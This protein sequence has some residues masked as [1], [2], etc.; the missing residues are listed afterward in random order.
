MVSNSLTLKLKEFHAISLEELNRAPLMNR[1]DEKFAFPLSKLEV[2]L[3][4]LKHYYDVLSIDN[5]EIFAYTSQYFDDDTFQFF[6]D[7]HRALPNRFKVRIRKYLDSGL[8]FLEV[9]EKIKGRTDKKRIAT[10]DFKDNFNKN[11]EE[12]LTYQLG[13]KMEL[14]P[15]LTNS[16]LR[17]TLVNKE[18]EE[19]LTLDFEI[20]NGFAE[21]GEFTKNSLESVVIAE[22]KQPVKDRNSPFYKLMK[23]SHIRPFRISKFCFAVMDLY[24]G[25][26][27]KANR[28][29]PKKLFLNKLATHV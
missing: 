3:D 28:F 10:S 27:L 22:L 13:K 25:P 20:R 19:R 2:Y 7:H 12:F 23:K 21:D 4:Y 17:I 5:R 24:D 29:K 1:V 9:K 18:A 8:T 14:K 15:V 11:E 26:N 6:Y 16:Y